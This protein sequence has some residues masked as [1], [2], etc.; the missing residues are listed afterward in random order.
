[1]QKMKILSNPRQQLLQD[2]KTLLIDLKQYSVENHAEMKDLTLLDD[3]LFQMDDLFMLVVAGEFNSGKSAFINALLGENIL[4]TGI[5]PTTAEIT[6]L[7]YGKEKTISIGAKGQQILRIP[8]NNLTDISIVD[9]PGTNAILREHEELTTDFIPRS[10]LV[11]FITSVDRPFTE[12][13]RK[14]IANIQEWGKKV[15]IIINKTDIVE[16]PQDLTKVISFVESNSERLLGFTP[17]IF[18]LSAKEALSSIIDT[19]KP[20]SQLMK[21]KDFIFEKL[22]TKNRFRLKLS[23]P[24]GILD[25]FVEKYSGINT[26]QRTLIQEDIQLLEDIH[27]QLTLFREDMIR[28]FNFRYADIDNA[29]LEFE[30]RGLEYFESTF[31]I[32]RVMDLLNKEKIKNDFEKIV[33]RDLAKIIDDKVNNLIDWVVEEDLKQWQAITGKINQR[34][35]KY[36]DRIF[37]DPEI[38]QFNLERQKI[39]ST[40]NREAQRIVEQYDK[41]DQASQIAEEAQTAV[42]ASAAIE[43]GAIGLGTL[44]TLLATTASADLTGILLAGLAA[45]LGFFIIP[46]KKRQTRNSF[47]KQINLLRENLSSSLLNEF[48]HQIDE[49]IEN[50]HNT[51]QPYGRF[52]QTEDQRLKSADANLDRME[53]QSRDLKSRIERY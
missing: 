44:V 49:I 40:I 37:S 34:S 42:A 4:D 39:I 29:L 8:N 5:T 20:S 25:N 36:R 43:V 30:K 19:G 51:I 41:D 47:S 16:N 18:T 6:I 2:T 7:R 10:D 14:F 52:I 53:V 31:R 11:L 46:A 17:Q 22:D 38:Q 15:V 3:L 26:T 21:I 13:E 33:I 27:K 45:T 28:A 35:S 12:S 48:S 50:I 24:I 32:A 9:T 23:N 1:M